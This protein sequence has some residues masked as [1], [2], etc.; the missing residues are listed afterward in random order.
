MESPIPASTHTAHVLKPYMKP[1][2]KYVTMEQQA[3]S[4]FLAQ[5]FRRRFIG[6]GEE[7][8]EDDAVILSTYA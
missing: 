5:L 4:H 7:E 2:G 1:K 6:G 8:V 3:R